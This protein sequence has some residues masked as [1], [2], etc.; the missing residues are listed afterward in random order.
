MITWLASYPKSGNTWIRLLLS[1][2][3]AGYCDINDIKGSYLDYQPYFYK[4]LLINKSE[5]RDVMHIRTAALYH[6]N[7]F[8]IEP[9]IKTHWG[10]YESFGIKAIPPGLTKRAIVVIRD[11]RDLV[12]SLANFYQQSY[13]QIIDNLNS[14]KAGTFEDYRYYLL[15]DWSTYI[16]SWQKASFPVYIVR[17]EDL[18]TNTAKTFSDVLKFM[19]LPVKNIDTIVRMTKFSRLQ[20]QEQSKGFVEQK[21]GATFFN[22]GKATW[23]EKLSPAQIEDVENVHK[24]EMLKFGYPLYERHHLSVNQ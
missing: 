8:F 11:P 15:A 13:D 18:L 10:N 17:Y 5:A 12:V 14:K 19:E 2:Y 6:M 3:Q 7:E 22:N 9:V 4:S 1:T 24:D 20:K 21:N 23:Q 16:Q